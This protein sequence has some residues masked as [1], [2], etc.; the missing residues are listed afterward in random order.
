[1]KSRC[2]VLGIGECIPA[3]HLLLHSLLLVAHAYTPL[4]EAFLTN[5]SAGVLDSDFNPATG[6]LLSPILV[7]RA[8]GSANHAA[9]LQ[10]FVGFFSTQLPKWKIEWANSTSTNAAGVEL[11]IAN[12][13]LSREPPW[14]Q[15]GQANWLTLAAHY[16]SKSLPDGLVAAADGAVPCTILMHAARSMDRYMTQMHDEMDALGE[17]GTVA[18]DMGVK[19]VFIDGKESLDGGKEAALYGSRDLSTVWENQKYPAGAQYPNALSQVRLFVL[20]DFLGAANPTVPSYSVDTHWAFKKMIELEARLRKMQLLESRPQATA[21]TFETSEATGRAVAA[22]DYVPFAQRDV[23]FLYVAPYPL[24]ETR[25]TVNDTGAHLDMP[26]V[27]D[28]VKIITGFTFEWLDMM[29]VW[30]E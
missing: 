18:M 14:T 1:M 15:A 20:L 22:A 13:V 2:L 21:F 5:I 9:V 4:N 24:P 11:P 30:P 16:D 6:S 8:P 28:W 17:G 27:R 23:P 10:H 3:V 26:T 29:E 7:P 12:L 19:I 25:H